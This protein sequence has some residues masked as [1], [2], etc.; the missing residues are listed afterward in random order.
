M[1]HSLQWPAA[2]CLAT[3]SKRPAAIA[4]AGHILVIP[5]VG[6]TIRRLDWRRLDG[7]Q[8]ETSPVDAENAAWPIQMARHAM[9]L[10]RKCELDTFFTG[11]LL[12]FHSTGLWW[13][14]EEA[15]TWMIFSEEASSHELLKAAEIAPSIHNLPL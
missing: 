8:C 7:T 9:D 12:I 15:G 3:W 6:E 11:G 14:T 5:I 2:T 13:R 1:R 4:E 10:V